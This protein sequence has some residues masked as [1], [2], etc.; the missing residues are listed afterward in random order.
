MSQGIGLRQHRASWSPRS[1]MW[2]GSGAK[3]GNARA[4]SEEL[5]QALVGPA[6]FSRTDQKTHSTPSIAVN[7]LFGRAPSGWR[8]TIAR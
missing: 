1:A 7:G 6:H 8:E 5:D 3:N 2:W 4:F